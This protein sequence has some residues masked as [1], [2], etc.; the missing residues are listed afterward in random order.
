MKIDS[1]KSYIVDIKYNVQE[2][3]NVKIFSKKKKAKKNIWIHIDIQ[4]SKLTS[5][6]QKMK[7]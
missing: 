3:R 7:P 2:S 1:L 6:C 5:V 4:I